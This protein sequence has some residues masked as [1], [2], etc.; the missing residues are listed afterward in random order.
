MGDMQLKTLSLKASEIKFDEDGNLKF[1]GYASVFGGVDSYNDQVIPGA[2]SE[3]IKNRTRPIAL[4]WNHYGP[5]I[6]KFTNILED[7]TGLFVEGELTKGHS[8]AEN[9]AASLR[10]GAISGLSIGYYPVKW[11]QDGDLR[12]LT[13]IELR[14]ISVVEE[15][16]DLDA[17]ITDLKTCESLKDIEA[18]LRH[19]HGFSQKEA[20]VM[21]A[22]VKRVDKHREGVSQTNDTLNLLN[23]F[24]IGG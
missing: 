10:H 1:S 5:I 15:P 23:N 20:T 22:A 14:E 24:K 3:T 9:V 6:G 11:E 21:V 19:K 16:A 13:Q 7:E 18:V 4:R 12:K 8:V 17:Q 2:Y